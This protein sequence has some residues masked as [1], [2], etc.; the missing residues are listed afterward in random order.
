MEAI[1]SDL[2]DDDFNHHLTNKKTIAASQKMKEIDSFEEMEKIRSGAGDGYLVGSMGYTYKTKK[3][4]GEIIGE[5]W[6]LKV[7]KIYG[8]IWEDLFNE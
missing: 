6:I 5:V 8:E 7:Q 4:K 2:L 3:S 1:Y